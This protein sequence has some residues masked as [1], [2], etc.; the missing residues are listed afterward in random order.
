MKGQFSP[1][2][3]TIPTEEGVPQGGPISP[4]ISNMVLNGIEAAVSRAV[5]ITSVSSSFQSVSPATTIKWLKNGV[6]FI[7]TFGLDS[8]TDIP[9]TL[10][11]SG[12]IQRGAIGVRA[13]LSVRALRPLGI[14]YRVIS[15][16]NPK[17]VSRHD[18][19]ESWSA[20][21]RF[22]DDCV[23]L[24]NSQRAIDIALKE[25][26]RFLT[27]TPLRGVSGLKLNIEKTKIK[28]LDHDSF[29]FVG[30]RFAIEKRHGK[31]NIYVFPPN[32]PFGGG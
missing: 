4:T 16:E 31:N 1:K 17:T 3:Q 22:A 6:P 8:Y 12:I 18:I 25:I 27:L 10:Q 13:A 15:F 29:D 14:T 19:N 5:R 21:F 26:F 11:Q 9:H 32:P 7:C 24:L 20:T 28:S 23:I 2:D 30:F